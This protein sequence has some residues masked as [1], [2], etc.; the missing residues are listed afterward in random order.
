MEVI[1]SETCSNKFLNRNETFTKYV[2]P[3]YLEI[4]SRTNQNK[5]EPNTPGT[6][7]ANPTCVQWNLK[8][9]WWWFRMSVKDVVLI[10]HLFYI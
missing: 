1:T 7:L 10:I 6:S 9:S 8:V 2:I 3:S 5:L 4:W